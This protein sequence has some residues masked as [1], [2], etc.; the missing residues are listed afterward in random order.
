[1]ANKSPLP[2]ETKRVNDLREELAAAIC[3]RDEA[4][5]AEFQQLRRG[6][7]V[8]EFAKRWGVKRSTVLAAIKRVE[9]R[10]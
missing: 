2:P 5:Y 10:K 8:A 4:M 3:R 6:Q 1:M 7:T 9:S